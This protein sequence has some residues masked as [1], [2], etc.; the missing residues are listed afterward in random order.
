MFSVSS[1]LFMLGTSAGDLTNNCHQ[2]MQFLRYVPI[3]NHL[4]FQIHG[5]ICNHILHLFAFWLFALKLFARRCHGCRKMQS[6]Y[7]WWVRRRAPR[8]LIMV[9][10]YF[11]RLHLI[12]WRSVKVEVKGDLYLVLVVVGDMMGIGWWRISLSCEDGEVWWRWGWRFL[13]GS[14]GGR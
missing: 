10:R 1:A 3:L 2:R 6:K 11:L 4:F 14:V 12:G 8:H 13:S 9:E 7:F 5:R